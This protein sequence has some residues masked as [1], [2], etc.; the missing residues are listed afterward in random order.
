MLGLAVTRADYRGFEVA[1]PLSLS[2]CLSCSLPFAFWQAEKIDLCF[3]SNTH[4]L[5]VS[6]SQR[7]SFGC[8]HW[9]ACLHCLSVRPL[10]AAQR[11]WHYYL[12]E[13]TAEKS[14]KNIWFVHVDPEHCTMTPCFFIL[15]DSVK[16]QSNMRRWGPHPIKTSSKE[17]SLW[18]PF[19]RHTI[20]INSGRTE[21]DAMHDKTTFQCEL[22]GCSQTKPVEM[23]MLP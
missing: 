19:T 13:S 3:Y 14:I 21:K 16:L 5:S 20:T 9:H 11:H 15:S 10:S 17:T 6:F 2:L 7:S 8:Q 23:W 4:S 12:R 22:W 1:W 18:S